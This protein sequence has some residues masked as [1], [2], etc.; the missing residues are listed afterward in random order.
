MC[1][2]NAN[3]AAY[4]FEVSECHQA[5]GTG[6]IPANPAS[7]TAMT[8]YIDSTLCLWNTWF[9]GHVYKD[10]RLWYQDSNQIKISWWKRMPGITIQNKIV[11]YRYLPRR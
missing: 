3:C 4:Y 8:V 5:D 1:T 7:S 6:L 10:M 2:A 9:L 11:Q